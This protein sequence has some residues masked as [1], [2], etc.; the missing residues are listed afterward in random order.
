M[1]F[2][3]ALRHIMRED[4]DLIFVGE[5]R[6]PD[7][8]QTALNAAETGHLVFTTM[9]AHSPHQA[10]SRAL[11]YF[12]PQQRDQMR[13]QLA[14]NLT[15]II[16]QKLVPN[17]AGIGL[18][19]VAELLLANGTIRKLIRENKLHKLSAA[20]E[21]GKGQGMQTFNNGLLQLVQSDVIKEEDAL[22]ISPYP[23]ALRLNLK[24]IFLDDAK[25]ILES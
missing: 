25:R 18:V 12:S 22:A 6:D 4:P 21:I 20:I 7:S 1:S 14:N 16:A 15:A 17:K 5:L 9:H 23:E 24:G 8:F 3:G 13:V 11:E 19:P 2:A 10:I